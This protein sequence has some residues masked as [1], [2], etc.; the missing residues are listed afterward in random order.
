MKKI[1]SMLLALTMTLSLAACG[2]EGTSA[3]TETPA[4]SVSEETASEEDTADAAENTEEA[5][6]DASGETGETAGTEVTYP[7]TVT[8]Q[9]GR[10]VTIEEE[11]EKLVSGY[12]ISTSLLI[13]LELDEKL[14]GIEAKADTRPIYQLSA[15]ALLE[16]PSVGTAKEFDLEGCAA[17][18]PDLVILPMSLQD[19]ADTLDGLGI[20]ALVVNPE[21]QE[22]LNEMINLI[23]TAAN[24][25]D[26]AE[27]LLDFAETQETRLAEA[28]ADAETPSVYLA[29]NSALLSTAGDAMYQSDLIRM[30][31]GVN[32][33]ADIT[34]TYWAEIS[35]EQL[36]AWDPDYIVLASDADYTVDDVLA[37]ENLA[38][39]AAVV[40]GNVYQIP[41]DAEAWDSPVPSGILGA[42]WLS[43]VL[44]PEECPETDSAAVID[45]FYE[46]FYGFT[47][48]EN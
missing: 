23:G 3:D 43:S 22:L 14:V 45:E 17:L 1:L 31:G 28:L 6:E 26:R 35:Y 9:A 7:V 18:E 21:D 4:A 2:S 33:A 16:L 12:Y 46:T 30:A 27:A 24:R 15:S 40:N 47:Y 8:D 32:A 36:L 20:D 38:D 13:A 42:V 48:S 39:C 41:G 34:D 11:P 44:H 37:D 10:E 19:T 5:P 25:Q 29:G